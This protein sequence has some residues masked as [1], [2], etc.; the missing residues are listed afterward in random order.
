ML[1]PLRDWRQ[2]LFVA[3]VGIGRLFVKIAALFVV[4][5]L[6]DN[7]RRFHPY[8][9]VRTATD[10]G[11]WNIAVRNGAHNYTN[12]P[13]VFYV[14]TSNTYDYSLENLDG[15]QW[16]YRKSIEGK[17]VSFRCTW[18]K[19]RPAKGKREFYIGWTM[20][21]TPDMRCTFFQFRPF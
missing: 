1:K 4:P 20:N 12:R 5:F 13:S 11:Y 9:G 18:G 19:P 3:K 7:R 14:S 21:E 8:F 17:Y 10:L 15:F 6:D 16:R 2:W